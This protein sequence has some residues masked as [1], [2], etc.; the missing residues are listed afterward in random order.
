MLVTS[1][2]RPETPEDTIEMLAVD[3]D[4]A[5]IVATPRLPFKRNGSGDVTTALFAGHYSET[6]DAS[7]ALART[8][9]SVFDLLQTTFEAGTEELQLIE[10]QEFFAHPRLQFEVTKI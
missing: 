2:N 1:V 5:F 4:R 6:K 10:S 7:I 9:S 3:G 8:A